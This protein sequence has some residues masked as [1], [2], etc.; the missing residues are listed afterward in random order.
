MTKRHW[1]RQLRTATLL[2]VFILLSA[3]C[4]AA[5]GFVGLIVPAVI[6]A[7]WLGA[8]VADRG[9]WS[10]LERADW[11]LPV[12]GVW[13]RILLGAAACSVLVLCIVLALTVRVWLR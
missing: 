2:L 1:A 10:Y 11:L 13:A 9:S 12:R 4:V 7:C 5:G 6:A 8:L 3:G